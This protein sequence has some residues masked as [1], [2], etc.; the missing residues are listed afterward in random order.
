MEMP[1]REKLNDIRLEQRYSYKQLAEATGLSDYCIKK[2]IY[3][4]GI[5]ADSLIAVLDVLGYELYF[6]EI[7]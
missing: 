4:E 6:K 3:G 2:F 5:N 1:I 7:K